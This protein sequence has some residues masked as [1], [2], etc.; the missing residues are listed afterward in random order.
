LIAFFG[1][2]R[3]RKLFNQA[4]GFHHRGDLAEAGRLYEQILEA[5]PASFEP[6]HLLGVI[7][8]QQGRNAE[9]L[10][11]IGAALKIN[12]NA[13]EALSSYGLVLNAL[14]R[15]DEAISSYDKALA[16]NP[17][18]LMAWNN[19]GSALSG[20]K[21]YEEALVSFDKAL[22]IKP[23]VAEALNNRGNALL[24]L[25]R[26]EEALVSI[27]KALAI[28]PGVAEALNNR[29]NALLGLKRFDQALMSFDKA[30]A[31]KP[32][33]AEA[34]NDRG[35]ALQELRR[36]G[37]A[38]ASYT[39]ALTI[40]PDYADAYYNRGNVLR[41]LKRLDE[42]QADYREALANKSDYAEAYNNWGNV[43]RDLNRLDEA[44][45]KYD[46]AIVH[47]SDYVEAHFN[48]SLLLLLKGD[49]DKGWELYEWR[50]RLDRFKIF[51]QFSQRYWLGAE[52]LEGKTILLHAEQG[53]GDTIQ[54]CRYAKPVSELGA[55]VYLEVQKPLV[56]VLR[57]VEGVTAV[58]E[59]GQPRPAFDYHCPLLSLP[60]AL[61]TKLGSIP[62][63]TPYLHADEEKVRYWQQRIG[64]RSKLNVGLVW[65]GGFRPDQPEIWA[66]NERRN[67]P[68]EVFCRGLNSV[69]ADFFSLQKGE[70][71]E[72]ELRLHQQDY[73]PN[74]NFHNF[75]DEMRD[76]SDTAGL[77]ANLDVIISV[78]TST[79]HLSAAIGKPTW[80]LNRFDTCWRWQLDRDDSPWY[81]SV[82]L[83]RQAEDQL[84]QPVLQRVASD[85]AKLAETSTSEPL[86]VDPHCIV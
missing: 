66:V 45:A 37:E 80:I 42:A 40:N 57:G 49:F 84:W 1:V 31:I 65:N 23:D 78:D 32:G 86:I 53:L 9:A 3:R 27:D 10:E 82:K 7:R 52:S 56:E 79:A 26:F 64:K 36:L 83:Y 75:M 62:H 20:L 43:L 59:Q 19:R 85:L 14:G 76:F 5:E 17:G 50:F 58:I 4:V 46:K 72:A 60:L 25:K 33:Y 48:K 39:Q 21:R 30:L 2:M 74:G 47:K 73:W 15:F 77:I 55:R 38:L 13:A 35:N 70:Q 12:P 67:V 68:L 8:H 61:K 11:F 81:Q 24:G 71:A 16:I 69:N 44:L 6:R 28:A 34:H 51:F 22:A 63:P 29:G 54:F 18:L 41:D